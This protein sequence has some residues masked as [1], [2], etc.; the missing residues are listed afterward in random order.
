MTTAVVYL[1]VVQKFWDLLCTDW[2]TLVFW[3]SVGIFSL[4]TGEIILWLHLLSHYT[5]SSCK[6]LSANLFVCQVDM[7]VLQT[8]YT[9][10]NYLKTQWRKLEFVHENLPREWHRW[11][12][13]SVVFFFRIPEPVVFFPL[14][15]NEFTCSQ[16]FYWVSIF[17]R[18]N[19]YWLPLSAVGPSHDKHNSGWSLSSL[20]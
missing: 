5:L 16:D 3:S 14:Y 8:S 12:E 15:K 6:F 11:S 1:I 2:I 10:V 17:A 7:N 18:I 9:S 13:N 20:R 4:S 19:I